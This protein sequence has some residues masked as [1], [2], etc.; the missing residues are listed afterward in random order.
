MRFFFLGAVAS[1]L[2]AV[3][4]A[5][6]LEGGLTPEES[7]HMKESIDSLTKAID[8]KSCDAAKAQV[9]C[10]SNMVNDRA[11]EGHVEGTKVSVIEINTSTR[12]RASL[13][14]ITSPSRTKSSSLR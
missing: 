10:L 4:A 5:V 2:A 11:M 6:P 8:T 1:A 13:T 14:S 9:L 7:K 12:A 3:A